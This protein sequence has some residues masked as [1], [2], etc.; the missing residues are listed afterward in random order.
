[1]AVDTGA[2]PTEL[3]WPNTWGPETETAA[4]PDSARLFVRPAAASVRYAMHAT[5]TVRTDLTGSERYHSPAALRC[6]GAAYQRGLGAVRA[7]EGGTGRET[8]THQNN[9]N[10]TNPCTYEDVCHEDVCRTRCCD[11]LMTGL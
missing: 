11:S 9:Q 8:P 2:P 1:M 5:Y 6:A 10:H 4:N 7:V 3:P